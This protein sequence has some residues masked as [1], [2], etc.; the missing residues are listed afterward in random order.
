M[1]QRLKFFIRVFP[2]KGRGVFAIEDIKKGEVIEVSPV[3]VFPSNETD[4]ISQT[5]LKDYVFLWDKEKSA[6]PL[7]VGAVFNHSDTPN[8]YY[9]KRLHREDMVFIATQDINAQEEI[10]VSYGEEWWKLRDKKPL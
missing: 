2:N 4:L 9:Q 1:T 6:L 3:V 7:G 8:S 5:Q 10:T